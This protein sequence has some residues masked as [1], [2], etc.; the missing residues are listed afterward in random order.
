MKKVIVLFLLVS[1][2]RFVYA[3]SAEEIVKNADM[4]RAPSSSFKAEMKIVSYKDET[5]VEEIE[6]VTYVR[7]IDSVMVEFTGPASWKGKKMLML[8]GDMWMIFPNASKPVRIT[9]AQRLMGEVSHGDISRINLARDY[10]AT[11]KR[12][13]KVGEIN[14]YL[15]ELTSKTTEGV[16]YYR[17]NYWVK[18]DDFMPVKAEFFALSGRK[19]KEAVYKEPKV[20][21]GVPRISKVILYDS[22]NTSKY[23]VMYYIDIKEQAIPS[24]YYNLNYLLKK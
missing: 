17:I 4:W 1:L 3:L 7:D 23:S 20:F 16:T 19:L 14:C 13:E 15:L 12:E 8:K 21:A 24:V 18:K 5:K 11:L 9:P 10:N 2:S 6:L 22:V